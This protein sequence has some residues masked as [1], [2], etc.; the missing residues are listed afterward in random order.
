MVHDFTHLN[1]WN[2]RLMVSATRVVADQG[3]RFIG[4]TSA[5]SGLTVGLGDRP[6]LIRELETLIH[7]KGACNFAL[8]RVRIIGAPPIQAVGRSSSPPPLWKLS[9]QATHSTCK[10]SC[11]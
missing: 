6:L 5:T 3:I 11:R 4:R 2:S 7:R 9:C 8:G 1:G 10:F